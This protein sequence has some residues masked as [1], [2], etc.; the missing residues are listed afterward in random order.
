M[1]VRTSVRSMILVSHVRVS[2]ER[3]LRSEDFLWMILTNLGISWNDVE[4]IY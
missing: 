2:L 4:C 1:A 3:D